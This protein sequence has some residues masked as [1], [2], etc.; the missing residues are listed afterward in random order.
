MVR[1]EGEKMG[2]WV[3]GKMGEN[4]R[5]MENVKLKV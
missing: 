2:E 3:Y 5:L 1:W 4:A